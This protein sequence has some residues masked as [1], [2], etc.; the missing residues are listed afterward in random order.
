MRREFGFTIVEVLISIV[1]LA[2]LVV[3][4]ALPILNF[5]KLNIQ[6]RDSLSATSQ[7]QKTLEAV[8]RMVISNYSYLPP[9]TIA[10]LDGATCTNISVLNTVMDPPACS[11]NANPPMRRLSVTKQVAGQ[12]SPVTLTVDVRP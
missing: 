5:Q 2:L 12:A 7:A 11:G 3:A 6:S 10:Q 4:V 1:L 9:L 8:R